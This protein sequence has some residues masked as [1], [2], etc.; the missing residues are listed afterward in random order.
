MLLW[1]RSCRDLE[2]E[3]RLPPMV[4]RAR[5]TVGGLE[6]LRAH[7]LSAVGL[8]SNARVRV[9]GVENGYCGVEFQVRSLTPT[10]WGPGAMSFWVSVRPDMPS[11]PPFSLHECTMEYAKKDHRMWSDSLTL[12]KLN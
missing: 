11:A 1:T 7:D 8:Y 4:Y 3:T 2:R 6:E 10:S 5:L 9:V 12:R